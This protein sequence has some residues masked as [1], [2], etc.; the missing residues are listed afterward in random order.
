MERKNFTLI[1]V[2]AILMSS[3]SGCG[4]STTKDTSAVSE[5]AETAEIIEETTEEEGR[6]AIS[7]GLPDTT[8]GGEEFC[9]L[10][11]NREDFINDIGVELELTG[12]VTDDAIYERNRS[13]EERFDVA[14]VGEYAENTGTDTIARVDAAVLA[15]DDSYDIVENQ[16]TQMAGAVTSGNYLDWYTQLPYVDLTKPWYV[17]NARDALSINGHA[18]A[19]IGEFNLDVLRFTYCMFYNQDI[20]AEYSLEDIFTVVKEGRWTYDQLKMLAD[21]VYVDLNGDGIK[22]FDDRLAI[23]GDPLSQ[24]VTYQYA[25]DN[26]VASL[27]SDGL[28]YVSLDREKGHDIVVKLNAL[29]WESIGGLTKNEHGAGFGTW[30]AGNSLCYTRNINT[31]TSLADLEFDFSIIPYPKYNEEQTNYYTMSDGAHG[32]MMIPKTISDKE[33]TSIIIE[34]LNAETYKQVVPAYFDTSLQN[35]YARDTGSSEMLEIILNGRVFDFGYI[36]SLQLAYIIRNQVSKNQ[37]NTESEY[38][39]KI[40]EAEATY[41]SIVE[42]YALLE[43]GLN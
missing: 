30:K 24:V 20:A 41:A 21:T 31:M 42:E 25:F 11:R 43:S 15:G 40:A 14:I 28:P 33:M 18:Y 23:T 12:D 2:L 10:T 6:L 8:F 38:A 34:A 4:G 32:T 26:P 1:L 3:L 37:S 36:H 17:G 35:R 39:S 19:M 27:D 29:Y 7:D 13:V 9:V 22:D 16:I 5:T